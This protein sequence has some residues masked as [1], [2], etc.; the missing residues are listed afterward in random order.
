MP[1]STGRATSGSWVLPS[2]DAQ[3]GTGP[4]HEPEDLVSNRSGEQ[5]QGSREHVPSSHRR[6]QHFLMCTEG[7]SI[8]SGTNSGVVS[9]Q[10]G[11]PVMKLE[12][13]RGFSALQDDTALSTEVSWVVGRTLEMFTVLLPKQIDRM[14]SQVG[15]LRSG[16]VQSMASQTRNGSTV[17]S[18]ALS[19]GTDT[20]LRDMRS[21]QHLAVVKMFDELQ[22]LHVGCV[23]KKGLENKLR[24]MKRRLD[25]YGMV[26]RVLSSIPGVQPQW[27]L[28][29][30]DCFAMILV[31]WLFYPSPAPSKPKEGKYQ[32]FAGLFQAATDKFVNWSL[33][34]IAPEEREN[35]HHLHV[36]WWICIIAPLIAAVV[37]HILG[38][39]ILPHFDD[40]NEAPQILAQRRRETD[41]LV[42]FCTNMSLHLKR[43]RDK[44]ELMHTNHTSMLQSLK[45]QL[46]LM[47]AETVQVS[48]LNAEQMR[49]LLR[50]YDFGFLSESFQ[51][52]NFDG[53]A[54]VHICTEQDFKR[55]LGIDGVALKR[56]VHFRKRCQSGKVQAGSMRYVKFVDSVLEAMCKD[57]KSLEEEIRVD[58]Q[59]WFRLT[60][61]SE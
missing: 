44:W 27:V 5:E 9:R 31:A 51:K 23:Q 33:H 18:L 34:H 52:H 22:A 57:A 45:N 10:Q 8:V 1:R 47:A 54:F 53:Y 2:D 20:V 49:D 50:T 21:G 59:D 25:N 6:P 36:E 48:D 39:L 46:S 60:M 56:L 16:A 11:S 15:Q 38:R 26:Y 55:D 37:V 12:D 41:K 7:G 30:V 24:S 32:G 3:A 40:W 42:N 61:A 19:D 14:S 13:V 35:D 43:T 28:P 4:E 29:C 17:P 58:W